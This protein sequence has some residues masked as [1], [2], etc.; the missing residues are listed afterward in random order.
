[1]QELFFNINVLLYQLNL[2]I[3]AKIPLKY[4]LL[5]ISPVLLYLG[6]FFQQFQQ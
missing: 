2:Y 5:M 4:L 6:A 3:Y 1:M